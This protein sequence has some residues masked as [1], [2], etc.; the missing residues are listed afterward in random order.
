MKDFLIPANVVK[1]DKDGKHFLCPVMNEMGIVNADTKYSDYNGKRYY[2]CCS[3][4]KSKFD[5]EPSKFLDNANDEKSGK[6]KMMHQ[7]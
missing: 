7:H 4:C 6:Q 3:N 5:A 1:Q 2:F